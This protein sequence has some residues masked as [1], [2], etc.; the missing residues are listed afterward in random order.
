MNITKF[1][2]VAVAT[3]REMA[4][5]RATALPHHDSTPPPFHEYSED[6]YPP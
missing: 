4:I 3:N 1:A 5:N 2:M 6:R